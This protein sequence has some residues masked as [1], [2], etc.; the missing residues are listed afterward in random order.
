LRQFLADASHELRTP[1]AAVRGY[2]ELYRIGAGRDVESV[3]RSMARIEAEAQRMGGLVE[4][5]LTLARLDQLPEA[6]HRPVELAEL[7]EHAADDAR[8]MAPTHDVRFNADGPHWVLADPDQLRQVLANLLRNAV[9]HTPP[10]TAIE[11]N[12][13]APARQVLLE[14]RDHG[15]GLPPGVGEEVFERFWRSE[16][17]RT[18]G[19]GGAGLGLAIVKAIVVA[20]RGEVIADNAP[21]GGASFRVTLPEAASPHSGNAQPLPNVLKDGSAT[22]GS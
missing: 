13:T 10:G 17:G 8:A 19:R 12:V 4:D 14:V 2:A 9:I 11:L 21:G 7:A 16:R 20:H 6:E 22:V 1:L 5:L 18:R 3:E 15:P